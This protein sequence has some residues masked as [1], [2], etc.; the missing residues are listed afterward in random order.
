MRLGLALALPGVNLSYS[1]PFAEAQHYKLV[2]VT[3]LPLN[4]FLAKCTVVYPT[5]AM[6]YHT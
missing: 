2:I 1:T 5:F 6:Q 3:A 4:P